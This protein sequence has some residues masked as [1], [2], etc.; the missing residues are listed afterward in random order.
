MAIA[1]ARLLNAAVFAPSKRA[2][3][4][5]T[6]P[7]VV[8]HQRERRGR[9]QDQRVRILRLHRG[10]LAQRWDEAGAAVLHRR[11]AAERGDHVGGGE[12][13]AVV[14]DHAAAQA[15]RPG[16]RSARE[17]RPCLESVDVLLD[18]YATQQP[19][20]PMTLPGWPARKV[21]FACALGWPGLIVRDHGAGR[22][23]D[24]GGLGAASGRRTG[25]LVECGRH[26]L[27]ATAANAVRA[28]ARL[29]A[30][31]DLVDRAASS[32]HGIDAPAAPPRV[33][34]VTH[35]GR[36]HRVPCAAARTAT[37]RRTRA[38]ANRP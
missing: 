30:H 15:E 6:A 20:L 37:R 38:R 12:R 4:I 7:N 5:V 11:H 27:A 8:R 13:R 24:S 26:W 36:A 14:P 17:L 28:A 22:L 19:S 16:E 18:L 35:T 21:R 33:V 31:L 34:T 32:G 29:V 2:G 23:R 1:A 9:A 3:T 10:D 25:L